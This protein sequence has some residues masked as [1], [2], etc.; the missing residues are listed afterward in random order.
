MN[1][2][3]GFDKFSLISLKGGWDLISPT[4]Q[5]E[6]G[7]IRD[8]SNFEISTS[9]G[10]SRIAGYERFDGRPSPSSASFSIIQIDAY[11]N[12]PAVGNTL[13]GFTSGA[14][15]VIVAILTSPAP[16]MVVTKV[17]GSYGATEQVRVGATVIGNRVAQTVSIT[18]LLSAQYLNLAADSYRADIGQVPGS[19]PVRGV[20]TLPVAGVDKTFAFRNNAGAT[21][22]AV[23]AASAA[24]WTLVAFPEEISF[25]AGAVATPADGAI[26]TQGA[27]TATVR[28]VMLQTGAFTGAGAG[29]FI[30]TNRAGGNYAAGAATLTG[31]TTCTLSGIQTAVTLAPSGKFE[32]IIANFFGQAS[33]Q[34]LYGCDGVN[35]AF[36]FDGTY[37]CPISTGTSPDA[38]KHILQ[39]RSFDAWDCKF[40]YSF[41]AKTSV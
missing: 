1:A 25:T 41:R 27:V 31:G 13:T 37:L 34:R 6:G 10:Y 4:L 16:Y 19:G 33:G 15:G 39:R 18:S 22:I 9:G 30:I 38:P 29:R 7:V 40:Y 2:P 21:A 28:R 24:G 17:V 23:Y 36:E 12:T 3:R 8:S 5:T 26:L 11:A 32:F 14:T 20:A 35:R